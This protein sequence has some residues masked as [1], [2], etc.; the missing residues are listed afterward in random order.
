M[1]NANYNYG[2]KVENQKVPSL[3]ESM[4]LINKLRRSGKVFRADFVKRG[5]GSVRT[6]VCRFGVKR[7]LKGGKLAFDAGDK[8][9]LTVWEFGKGFRSIPIDNIILI[10]SAGTVYYFNTKIAPGDYT[11]S[12]FDNVPKV[13]R[14][15]PAS[16]SPMLQPLN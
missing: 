14:T 4:N 2:R 5:D 7:Y 3:A 10:K 8:G 6:M 12:Y 16:T 1:K 9:L 15:I 11:H 13:T